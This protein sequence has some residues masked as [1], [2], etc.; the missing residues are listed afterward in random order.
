MARKKVWLIGI[1]VAVL[2]AGA[3]YA[4]YVNA[5]S[6]SSAVQ[7]VDPG[8][9]QLIQQVNENFGKGLPPSPGPPGLE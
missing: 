2:I 6:Q 7:R 8:K 9:A 4:Y 3:V 5:E 1:V